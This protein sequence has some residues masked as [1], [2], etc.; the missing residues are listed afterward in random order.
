MGFKSLCKEKDLGIHPAEKGGGIVI[1]DKKDYEVEMYRILNEPNTYKELPNN[2]TSLYK[3][4]L[5]KIIERVY[6]QKISNRKERDFLVLLAPRVPTIYY[7]PKVH[8]N[9]TQPPGQPIVS[10]INSVTLRIGQYIDFFLQPLVRRI[11]SY[12]KDTGATIRLLEGL[13]P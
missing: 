1:L 12:L 10:G 3:R 2:P 4:Q 13:A 11:Q 6:E 5:S 7:L 8:K 9:L